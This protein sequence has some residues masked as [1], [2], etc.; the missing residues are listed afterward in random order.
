MQSS[1]TVAGV[2]LGPAGVAEPETDT[3]MIYV[4]ISA[5]SVIDPE[6][7]AA[8]IRKPPADKSWSAPVVEVRDVG[9]VRGVLVRIDSG[10]GDQARSTL[11]LKLPLGQTS[12]DFMASA[13][14]ADFE[15]RLADYQR[16]LLSVLP[17]R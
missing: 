13:P 1:K 8:N 9:S 2:F 11:V 14:R 12:V 17:A 5:A 4:R 15:R 7:V 16:V 3:R 6:A 10:S